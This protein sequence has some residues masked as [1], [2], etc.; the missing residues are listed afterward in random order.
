MCQVAFHQ[1]LLPILSFLL[2]LSPCF[3]SERE[4]VKCD[5]RVISNDKTCS[6]CTGSHCFVVNYNNVHSS[7]KS[8]QSYYQ[9]CFTSPTDFPLGCSKNKRGSVFCICNTTDYCNELQNVKDE[10]SL[11]YVTCEVLDSAYSHTLE[12]CVHPFCYKKGSSYSDEFLRCPSQSQ[13][14]EMYDIGVSQHGMF[15]P[16]DACYSITDDSRYD[17]EQYCAFKA[18]KTTPFKQKVPGTI[19]CFAKGDITGERWKNSTCVGQFCFTSMSAFGCISQ[20]NR[21]GAVFKAGLYH[22]TPFI[23]PFYICDSDFCNNQTIS[24]DESDR[25]YYPTR[26]VWSSGRNPFIPFFILILVASLLF[27]SAYTD[28]QQQEI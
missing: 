3:G 13:E 11:T 18:N 28:N 5:G 2:V 25:Y 20:F 15:L 12:P 21:E 4:C 27:L 8:E 7:L 9:G 6:N 10:K 22:L 19:K 14:I 23:T 24:D 26:Y 16:L 17:K 1:M